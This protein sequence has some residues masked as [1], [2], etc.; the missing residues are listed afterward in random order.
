MLTL[1]LVTLV[2]ATVT[3]GLSAGVFFA[4]DS[5]VMPGLRDQDDAR[6]VAVMRSPS[7]K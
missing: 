2:V 6:F 3:T 7:Q 1:I 5:S 4:F